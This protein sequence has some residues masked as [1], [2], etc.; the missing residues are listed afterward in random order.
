M[1]LYHMDWQD[2]VYIQWWFVLSLHDEVILYVI[3][4]GQVNNQS[5]EDGKD[6]CS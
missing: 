5:D 2:L 1:L 4:A 6:W 3:P